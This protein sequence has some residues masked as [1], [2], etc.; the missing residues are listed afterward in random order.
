MEKI[1]EEDVGDLAAVVLGGET[2]SQETGEK[3]QQGE[4]PK[5]YEELAPQPTKEEL[6]G[7]I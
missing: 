1:S 4:K 7:F 5:S 6:F 3:L 2:P